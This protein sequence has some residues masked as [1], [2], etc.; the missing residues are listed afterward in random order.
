MMCHETNRIPE[1]LELKSSTENETTETSSIP[2][3][4]N[5]NN[6]ATKSLPQATTILTTPPAPTL[7]TLPPELRLLILS[8]LLIL[9]PTAP[10]PSQNGFPHN[11]Q[12]PSLS[13]LHPSILQCSRQLHAE[14]LP[15]LYQHNTYLA[16][17]TLLLSLPRL[18]RAYA[19][20]LCAR[21]SEMITRVH[22]C[23]R[24][25]AEPGY[26]RAMAT[27]QLS[28]KEEVVLEAWQAMWRGSGPDVLRLFEGVRGVRRARVEGSVGGFEDY[29][30]WLEGA[31]VREVGAVVE[32]FSWGAEEGGLT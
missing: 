32:P 7:L 3:P 11:P 28:G 14:G 8:H 12:P 2:S 26:D 18:R 25:D 24:L 23:V 13:L 27:A 17:N 22:V 29:A 19:P 4:P 9:P 30:R 20:V 5:P 1:A 15:L 6:P 21:L 10:P 16:H 31:M